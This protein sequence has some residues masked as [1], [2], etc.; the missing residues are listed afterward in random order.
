MSFESSAARAEQMARQ[1]LTR[2]RVLP[3]EELV[4]K[5]DA[6]TPE[7]VGALTG[8][9]VGGSPSA[10]VVGAGRG[11]MKFAECATRMLAS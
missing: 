9:L 6:V 5:V 10:A 2:G 11:S 3:A 7:D 8:R 4:Q 1:V